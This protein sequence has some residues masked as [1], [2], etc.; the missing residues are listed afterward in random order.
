M[1][2]LLLLASSQ[3]WIVRTA[4]TLTILFV[5]VLFTVA[6]EY[7][8]IANNQT[9][10]SINIR[11]GVILMAFII[12]LIAS[13]IFSRG[14]RYKNPAIC[15]MLIFILQTFIIFFIVSFYEGS[16][17]AK[18]LAFP[19]VY[20]LGYYLFAFRSVIAY[21]ICSFIPI[22]WLSRLYAGEITSTIKPVITATLIKKGLRYMAILYVIYSCTDSFYIYALGMDIA[23]SESVETSLIANGVFNYAII[24]RYLLDAIMLYLIIILLAGISKSIREDKSNRIDA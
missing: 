21:Q 22:K 14:A 3:K 16:K 19:F 9:M 1:D 4:F 23:S 24:G 11:G 12:T 6:I 2:N 5:V 20:V 17:I 10:D 15:L 18:L 13:V 8:L 7:I